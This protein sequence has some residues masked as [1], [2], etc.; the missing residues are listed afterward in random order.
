[1]DR[2]SYEMSRR[3]TE[4][5]RRTLAALRATWGATVAGPSEEDAAAFVAQWRTT[6]EAANA[7]MAELVAAYLSAWSVAHG[8]ESTF[9]LDPSDYI[10][11]RPVDYGEVLRRPT[12]EMRTAL[13]RGAELAD[14]LNQAYGRA[15]SIVATDLQQVHRVASRDG[16]AQQDGIVGYRRVLVGA[17]NCGLCM[18]AST[19]TYHKAR[20]NPIHPGCDCSIAPITD[21]A[22]LARDLPRLSQ[23][24]RII[25][26]QGIQ[27]T[28]RVGLSNLQI[29]TD[30]LDDIDEVPHGEL[31]PI[32]S[33][34]RHRDTVPDWVRK[35][36]G[37]SPK[38]W[39]PKVVDGR[40]V[41]D[42]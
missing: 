9:T 19:E 5:R 16:M 40:F 32:L 26:E 20:L 39:V 36:R 2:L 29:D 7:S 24:K 13:S 3:K 18:I 23:A 11:P 38:G 31:G 41:D 1:M 12:V 4:L 25:R 22:Q 10:N 28:D 42:R 33:V 6:H 35:D 30:L 14:A 15:E 34:R 27:Y 17:T 37:R 21:A 8:L